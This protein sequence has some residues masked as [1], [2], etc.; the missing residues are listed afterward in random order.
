MKIRSL[1]TLA[2]FM[3]CIIIFLGSATATSQTLSPSDDWIQEE[4]LKKHQILRAF[5]KNRIIKYN[6]QSID[7]FT[8]ML[9][10]NR[11][12]KDSTWE[13]RMNQLFQNAVSQKINFY[14]FFYALKDEPL[15]L[16]NEMNHIEKLIPEEKYHDIEPHVT[17][18]DLIAIQEYIKKKNLSV[19]VTLGSA[20]S[21]LITPNYPENQYQYPFA[22]HSI[23]K[24]FTGVLVF[25]MIEQGVLTEEDLQRPVQLDKTV[26]QKLPSSVK[27]QLKKV[28]LYQLM[29]HQSGLGDYL[30]RYFQAIQSGHPPVIRHAEDFLPFIED[31]V[32]P[33]GVSRYSNA[34]LLL[35]GLAIKH[36][37]EKKYK[38]PI[39]YDVLLNN[40][41][42]HFIG[43]T[44]FSILKPENAKYNLQDPIAPF[45]AGSPAGGYWVTSND[46]A[47]F[48]QWLYQ[49]MTND[50]TFN[51]L[52][53][54]YGQEFYYAEEDT[55]AH[56]GGIPSSSAF[57]SVSLKTGA[58]L[59][60]ESS[61]PPGFG[62]DLKT[63]IQHHIN[64]VIDTP[65]ARATSSKLI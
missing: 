4:F 26:L 1:I 25:M 11:F 29:I 37:Y 59:V 18:A 34:G 19:S 33:V 65:D 44:S 51:Y 10:N 38:H 17:P 6:K 58:V 55:I 35:V 32:Y 45:I 20:K 36:A 16:F 56:G 7:H 13:L 52:I 43:M 46:L 5:W 40:M 53:K 28:T 64:G 3:L 15:V 62:D 42:I 47:K 23:G 12:P 14:L 39:N 50:P 30:P 61:Q 24:V 31:E 8:S 2:I 49:K 57:F 54:K 48:G 41:L 63:M 60:V 21:E 22:I 27:I 9:I